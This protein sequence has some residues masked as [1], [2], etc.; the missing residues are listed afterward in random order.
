MTKGRISDLVLERYCLGEVTRREWN[1]VETALKTDPLVKERLDKLN[2]SDRELRP[3]TCR[4]QE[5]LAAMESGDQAH[6]RGWG[7]TAA[8]RRRRPLLLG[9]AAAALLCALLPSAYRIISRLNA[10]ADAF[11]DDGGPDRIK[12]TALTS[13]RAVLSL[14]LK[15]TGAGSDEA[16]VLNGGEALQE[17]DMVQL[18]YTAPAGDD[19]YG[20]I[21]SI[22]GRAALTMHYPY[23]REQSSFLVPGKHTFLD[24][25]YI[26]DDAPDFEIFF[27]VISRSPLKAEEVIKTAEKLALNPWTSRIESKTAFAGCDVEVITIQKE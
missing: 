5:G 23:R 2:E 22:D 24:E 4:L 13:D 3:I 10:A 25:A 1:L 27:M 18:A 17:G 14:Y 7:R 12:G 15:R 26:L 19:H 21:F 8:P 9:L 11:P 20:V 16:F 6:R